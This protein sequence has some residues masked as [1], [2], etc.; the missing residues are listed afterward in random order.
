MNGW[1]EV[2]LAALACFTIVQPFG[3]GVAPLARGRRKKRQRSGTK[4]TVKKLE[5]LVLGKVPGLWRGIKVCGIVFEGGKN[6]TITNLRFFAKAPWSI[7]AFEA[8]NRSG[9]TEKVL[10]H[11]KAILRMKRA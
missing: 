11:L 4:L 5:A 10:A 1:G 6:G 3:L 8:E 2:L 7:R 9:R